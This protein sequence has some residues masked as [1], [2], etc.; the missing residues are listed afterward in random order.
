MNELDILKEKVTRLIKKHTDLQDAYHE[1]EMSIQKQEDLL[2]E[3]DAIINNLEQ[4]IVEKNLKQISTHL[5]DTEKE[6][7]HEQLDK[8][9]AQIEKTIQSL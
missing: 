5:S 1:L 9:I 7:L 8:I 6:K 3:K 4:Q 2:N